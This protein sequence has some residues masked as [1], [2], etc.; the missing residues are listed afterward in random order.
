MTQAIA[1][2]LYVKIYVTLKW[3]LFYVIHAQIDSSTFLCLSKAIYVNAIQQK[4][5][6]KRL[7]WKNARAF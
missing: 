6:L 5:F 4:R 1:E 2:A 3:E 7:L